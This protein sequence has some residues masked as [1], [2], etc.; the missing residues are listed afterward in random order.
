MTGSRT[1]GSARRISISD[2][3]GRQHDSHRQRPVPHRNGLIP[4]ISNSSA[5]QGVRVTRTNLGNVP[6]RL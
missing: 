4:V 3:L 6:D 5:S 1:H 2:T